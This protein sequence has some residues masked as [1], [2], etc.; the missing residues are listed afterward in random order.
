VNLLLIYEQNKF[1]KLE[2]CFQA[3]HLRAGFRKHFFKRD[4]KIFGGAEKKL[5]LISRLNKI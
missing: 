2:A 3:A 1:T 5:S 4:Y